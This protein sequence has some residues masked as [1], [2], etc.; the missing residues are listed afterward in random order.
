MAGGGPCPV[1]RLLPG[2]LILRMAR[3]LPKVLFSLRLSAP[4]GPTHTRYNNEDGLQCPRSLAA[5]V[6]DQDVRE[7]LR[8]ARRMV[9]ARLGRSSQIQ[10]DVCPLGRRPQRLL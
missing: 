2:T 9:Q 7:D 4:S 8:R 1:P 5:W 10:R 3:T 6:E